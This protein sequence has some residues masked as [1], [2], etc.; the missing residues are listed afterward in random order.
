MWVGGGAEVLAGRGVGGSTD[1][2]VD[3]GVAVGST[4]RRVAD[5]VGVAV[6]LGVSVTVGVVVGS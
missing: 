2:T 4:S 6:M 5:G 3:D 1:A